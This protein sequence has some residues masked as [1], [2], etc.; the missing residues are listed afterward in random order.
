MRFVGEIS[1]DESYECGE[2]VATLV[3][4]RFGHRSGLRESCE[5]VIVAKYWPKNE[6]W[7]NVGQIDVPI[8][9]VCEIRLLIRMK[10]GFWPNN[11]QIKE[12]K[13]FIA[14][15]TQNQCRIMTKLV[16]KR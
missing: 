1:I 11:G 15:F 2:I 9:F 10:N 16:I 12:R 5:G 7:P 3:W 6:M 13:R 4:P 8:V 14:D